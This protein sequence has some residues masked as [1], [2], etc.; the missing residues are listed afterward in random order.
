MKI[1]GCILSVIILLGPG[2]H[3]G[4]WAET[5]VSGIITQSTRWTSKGSPYIIRGDIVVE[6]GAR[7]S[8]APG[9][10]ILV[11]PPLH[12]D[13]DIEQLDKTDSVTTAIK[14]K[15]M[16]SCIGR[17]DN[18]ITFSPLGENRSNCSW[19]GIVFDGSYDQLTEIAFT[20][21]AG[22]CN[23]VVA[24]TCSPIIRNSI[25]E[26]NNV[27]IL[28]Q[29]KGN[30]RVYNCVIASNLVCGIRTIASN[31]VFYSNIITKNKNNGV[32]CDG[33][34]RIE[35]KYNC[36]Y[37][38]TD[39][40]FLDCNPELGIISEK[41]A[42]DSADFA[43]NIFGNPIF[44]G[45]VGDSIAVE[46]DITIPTEKSRVSDTLLAKVLHDKLVDSLAAHRRTQSHPRYSLSPYSPCRDAGAPFKQLKD[47]DGSRNDIGIYGGPE[48]LEELP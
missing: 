33:V 7:L 9:T 43:H 42:E 19:Y 38:N 11:A 47:P 24:R 4:I 44:A 21:I 13:S 40:N 46:R 16:L 45:S 12:Y 25:I 15:G 2:V 41:H 48:F 35:F 10:R 14:I 30:A 37:G 34:S 27:G 23:G 36:V 3:P 31:P 26:F 22:A 20:D 39:G 29:D 17:R 5:R 18:R 1:P 6:K 28:C 8:I 32:W